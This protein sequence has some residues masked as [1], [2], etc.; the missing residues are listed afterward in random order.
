MI[1]EAIV[2]GITIIAVAT[3]GLANAILKREDARLK[4]E[5]DMNKEPLPPDPN[6]EVRRIFDIKRI[7]LTR[8]RDLWLAGAQDNF[9]TC[10]AREAASSHYSNLNDKLVK[11]A[12]DELTALKKV[13]TE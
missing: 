12:D 11:L 13:G 4:L 10:K 6:L 8:E 2:G 5:D 3:I 1:I 9:A 7:L